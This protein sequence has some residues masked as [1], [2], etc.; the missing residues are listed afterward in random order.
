MSAPMM[1]RLCHVLRR[2]TLKSVS[3][4]DTVYNISCSSQEKCHIHTVA[5]T[6]KER[7]VFNRE[8]LRSKA[9]NRTLLLSNLT[10]GLDQRH[11]IH[12]SGG[13]LSVV[14]GIETSC[15]DTG[16]AVVDDKGNILGEALHSQSKLHVE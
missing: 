9:L 8:K 4:T 3:I 6:N 2:K 5:L 7:H 12:T 15:D 16:A 13:L 1:S 10:S 14:L 11:Q